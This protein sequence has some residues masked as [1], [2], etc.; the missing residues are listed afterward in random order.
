MLLMSSLSTDNDVFGRIKVQFSFSRY[1]R[2]QIH[3]IQHGD[4]K[5]NEFLPYQP[6]IVKAKGFHK[7]S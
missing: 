1:T 5:Q 6:S 7:E 2:L 3:V 4:Q